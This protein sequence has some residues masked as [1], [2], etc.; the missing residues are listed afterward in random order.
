MN[1]ATRERLD[2]KIAAGNT[3]RKAVR[4]VEVADAP[5]LAEDL[6]EKDKRHADLVEINF[7]DQS[8]NVVETSEAPELTHEVLKERH[9]PIKTVELFFDGE[10]VTVKVRDGRTFALDVAEDKLRANYR[11][12]MSVNLTTA[13]ENIVGKSDDRDA[14][15]KRMA[16]SANMTTTDVVNQM[17]DGNYIPTEAQLKSFEG[18]F[19]IEEVLIKAAE[20]DAD[21]R[22]ELILE[23]NTAL[24][25]LTISKMLTEP[26]F[27]YDDTGNGYPIEERSQILT[28]TL[29]EAYS[30][31]NTPAENDIYQVEVLRGVPIEA[32]ILLQSGFELYPLGTLKKKIADLSDEEISQIAASNRAQHQ[33]LVASMLKKLNLSF[34]GVG[35]EQAYPV[36]NLSDRCLKTLHAAYKVVT[37]PE[38]RLSALSRFSD[39][40]NR[41][42]GRADMGSNAVEGN[43]GA[44]DARG[45]ALS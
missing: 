28:N 44:D 43:G 31:V 11:K 34:N 2:S 3:P 14:L 35:R 45:G 37:I 6:I 5:L 16:E 15:I 30:V 10:D 13:L 21:K 40:G 39:A 33:I 18:V 25:H 19:D 32:S 27:S 38:A 4:I 26:E 9:Q 12:R 24:K 8:A 22:P 29:F 20:K 41:D 17:L 23:L 36:E 7:R 1:K 42:G